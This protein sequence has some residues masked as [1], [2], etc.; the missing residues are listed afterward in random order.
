[1]HVNSTSSDYFSAHSATIPRKIPSAM[2]PK[3]DND[4]LSTNLIPQNDRHSPL[5]LISTK[6]SCTQYFL[7]PVGKTK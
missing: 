7:N 5:K 4:S 1:M 2:K 6:K 3:L